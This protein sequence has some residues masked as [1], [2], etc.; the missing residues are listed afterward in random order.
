[1]NNIMNEVEIDNRIKKII[2]YKK[3]E[4]IVFDKIKSNFKNMKNYYISTNQDNIEKKLFDLENKIKKVENNHNTFINI[5]NKN[6]TK[7][8]NAT[9]RVENMFDKIG[10][11]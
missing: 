11:Q 10:Y 3:S 5:L 4:S 9:K 6:L 2:M 1:M 8:H 7:Y